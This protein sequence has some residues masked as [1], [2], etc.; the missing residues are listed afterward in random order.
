MRAPLLALALLSSSTALLRPSPGA[1]RGAPTRRRASASDDEPVDD[2]VAEKLAEWRRL[3][4]EG[5]LYESSHIALTEGDDEAGEGS[6]AADVDNGGDVDLLGGGSLL[7]AFED[8]SDLIDVDMGEYMEGEDFADD[9]LSDEETS[10]LLAGISNTVVRGP[11]GGDKDAAEGGGK[12]KKK[13]ARSSAGRD[14]G[15]GKGATAQEA[16]KGERLQKLLS[17]AGV[18]SRRE[19]ERYIADGRVRVDGKLVTE[20]GRRFSRNSRITVDGAPIVQRDAQS[21]FWAVLNKPKGTLVT[22]KDEKGRKTVADLIPRARG[23]RLLPVGRLDRD[24]AGLVLMTNDNEWVHKLGHPSFGHTKRYRVVVRGGR[25][26]GSVLRTLRSG[27][28]LLDDDL[29]PLAPVAVEELNFYPDTG[30]TS[31]EIILVEG[32]N[33]QIRRMMAALGHE[34]KSITRTAM[35]PIGLGALK[36]GEWRTLQKHEVAKLKASGSSAP[37]DKGAGGKGKGKRRWHSK[38]GGSSGHWR[39][40]R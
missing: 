39:R 7:A 25:I 22:M 2:Q 37:E 12:A 6:P 33:R 19:A 5:K 13:N 27:G 11:P 3:A 15:R 34:V 32:R 29:R 20:L 8:E 23:L 40:K 31:L 35:G 4:G 18:C 30:E 10:R 16:P 9:Y 14:E 26:D 21:T 1:L 36:A 28:L 24:T 38:G 17:N